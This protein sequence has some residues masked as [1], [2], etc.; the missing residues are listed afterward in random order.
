[1]FLHLFM[2][3]HRIV[4]QAFFEDFYAYH[5]MFLDDNNPMIMFLYVFTE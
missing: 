3:I 4:P 2:Y 5:V 1:M